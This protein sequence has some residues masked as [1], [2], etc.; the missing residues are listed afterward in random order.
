SVVRPSSGAIRYWSGRLPPIAPP[1]PRVPSPG[2]EAAP[3]RGG[4]RHRVSVFQ[5]P[6]RGGGV[7]G[8][9]PLRRGEALR[10]LERGVRVHDAAGA[11]QVAEAYA[12]VRLAGRNP[13]LVRVARGRLEDDAPDVGRIEL[14]V[15]R[16]DERGEARDHG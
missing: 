8:S 11:G 2:C 14:R 3:A 4:R 10:H 15:V 1:A 12:A 5:E 7:P 9:V 16:H 6:Y 13:G